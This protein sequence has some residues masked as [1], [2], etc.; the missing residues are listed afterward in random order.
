MCSGDNHRIL[1]GKIHQAQY[2]TVDSCD[3]INSWTYNQSY[4][5]YRSKEEKNW[6]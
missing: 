3:N 6:E 5:S 4:D 1:D 2:F